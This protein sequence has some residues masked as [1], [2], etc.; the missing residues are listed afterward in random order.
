MRVLALTRQN[1]GSIPIV[2]GIAVI[3]LAIAIPASGVR[4]YGE[5]T[6]LE[7]IDHEDSALCGQFGLA[8]R[9]T[10]FA[11]CMIALAGL[12]QHHVDLLTSYSLL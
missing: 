12:R 4:P 9:T 2:L 10:Q 6:I 5:Q 11:D 3:S 8:V 1:P 7:R